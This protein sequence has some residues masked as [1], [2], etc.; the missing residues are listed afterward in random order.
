[1]F[2]FAVSARRDPWTSLGPETGFERAEVL[3]KLGKIRE[4]VRIACDLRGR[5]V[6]ILGK[7]KPSVPLMNRHA[8]SMFA[9]K[10]LKAFELCLIS[11]LEHLDLLPVAQNVK[12]PSCNA[13][14]DGGDDGPLLPQARFHDTYSTQQCGG[15]DAGSIGEAP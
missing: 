6:G 9:R 5:E 15:S 13:G 1:M 8:P 4:M 10:L 12:S 7:A 11:A 2:N 14:A 3:E